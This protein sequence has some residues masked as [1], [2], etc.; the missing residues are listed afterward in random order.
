MQRR[1]RRRVVTAVVCALIALM[2]VAKRMAN[3]LYNMES[4]RGEMLREEVYGTL[5]AMGLTGYRECY[6][7]ADVRLAVS[8]G[9]VRVCA[10]LEDEDVAEAR[11]DISAALAAYS[12]A[13]GATDAPTADEV[14]AALATSADKAL[15]GTPTGGVPAFLF[16]CRQSPDL[17][18]AMDDARSGH[19]AGDAYVWYGT[20]YM[21]AT[22]V[23]GWSGDEGLCYRR[24]Y[25][26]R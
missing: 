17:V 4:G 15:L 14:I 26:A 12:V 18:Y 16:W 8:W 13:T 11:E 19:R 2:V 22:S 10:T 5:E 24:E 9:D 7:D 6:E 20:N 1:R 23:H 21:W 25:E 3:T